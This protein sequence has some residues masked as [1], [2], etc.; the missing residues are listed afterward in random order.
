MMCWVFPTV[1]GRLA[2]Y[3]EEQGRTKQHTNGGRSLLA[4]DHRYH[5]SYVYRMGA[6]A[7][8]TTHSCNRL[9]SWARQSQ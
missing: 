6:W 9:R 2:N 8:G 7:G 1:Q 3:G 5:I 4:G